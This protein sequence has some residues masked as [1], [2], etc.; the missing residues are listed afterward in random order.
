MV[1]RAPAE[2]GSAEPA[3]ALAALVAKLRAEL[4]GVRTAMRNRAVIEQAKGVLVERLGITPDQGFDQLVRLSQRTNIK[5]IEVAAAIVGTTSPDPNAPDVVNLIDDELRQHVA[6][7]RTDGSTAKNPKSRI[8][9][10]KM[11]ANAP[12]ARPRWRRCSPSTSC[13]A[14]GSRRRAAT[15]R[16]ATSWAPRRRPG[17]RRARCC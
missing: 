8:W 15:T 4:T 10:R 6:R 11:P 13:S 3:E 1:D 16:S 9:Y 17:R 5:L 12:V 7:N 2:G 14:P